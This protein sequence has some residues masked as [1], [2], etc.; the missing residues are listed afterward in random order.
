MYLVK[1]ELIAGPSEQ[2]DFILPVAIR[3]A[4]RLATLQDAEDCGRRLAGHPLTVSVWIEPE[5]MLQ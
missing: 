3:D 2:A 1:V 4:A 5:D